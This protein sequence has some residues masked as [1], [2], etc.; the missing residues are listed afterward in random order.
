MP[1]LYLDH[2]SDDFKAYRATELAKEKQIKKSSK[3]D[4]KNRAEE[5][6]KVPFKK[7][8]KNNDKKFLIFK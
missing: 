3:N 7:S 6:A 8:S 4:D 1:S 5:L 2:N